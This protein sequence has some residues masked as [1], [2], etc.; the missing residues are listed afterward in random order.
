MS[1]Y[2][3]TDRILSLAGILSTASEVIRAGEKL[4]GD[5][6]SLLYFS[7][8]DDTV[9]IHALITAIII[10]WRRG[11]YPCSCYSGYRRCA[12]DMMG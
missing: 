5:K 2:I 8:T 3:T 6:K 1:K 12:I 7:N 9:A 10:T 11:S 4:T